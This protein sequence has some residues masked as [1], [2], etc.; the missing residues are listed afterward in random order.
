MVIAI[1]KLGNISIKSHLRIS[2]KSIYF[3]IICA[4]HYLFIYLLTY[5]IQS[6]IYQTV[7]YNYHFQWCIH[8]SKYPRTNPNDFGVAL[9]DTWYLTGFSLYDLFTFL[10]YKYIF[11]LAA[12]QICVNF[13]FFL[14][15]VW[16]HY[17]LIERV[18]L[19]KRASVG[20]AI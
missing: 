13:T 12:A 8:P 17:W 6:N 7:C 15:H 9:Y 4:N 1:K 14:A 16:F 10:N 5:L 18:I 20:N 3:G 2:K 11:S 19:K